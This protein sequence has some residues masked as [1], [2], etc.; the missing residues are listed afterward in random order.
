MT[1]EK[2]FE[3]KRGDSKK[4][5]INFSE[6]AMLL[7]TGGVVAMTV[8]IK[9]ADSDDKAVIQ[10]TVPI[11]ATDGTGQ[12]IIQMF[13]ND[14]EIPPKTYYHDIQAT[15]TDKLYNKTLVDGK[16]KILTDITRTI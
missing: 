14:N 2:D 4:V 10:K 16:Y 5:T 15:S 6:N 1:I 9:K 12:A 11:T 3:I 7:L 8:K 13:P